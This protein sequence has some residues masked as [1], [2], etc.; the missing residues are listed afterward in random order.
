M[1][2]TVIA[3]SP[4]RDTV[5]GDKSAVS[6]GVRKMLTRGASTTKAS[7]LQVDQKNSRF[8]KARGIHLKQK[9][10]QTMN[11]EAKELLDENR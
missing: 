4:K 7:T 8:V 9:K 3:D 6:T 5:V 1:N 11:S 10:L 2:V